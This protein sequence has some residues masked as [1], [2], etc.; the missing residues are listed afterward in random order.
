MD[1]CIFI[2][3]GFT[4]SNSLFSVKSV[5]LVIKNGKCTQNYWGLLI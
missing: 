1:H 5:Y 3:L 4:L 2:L